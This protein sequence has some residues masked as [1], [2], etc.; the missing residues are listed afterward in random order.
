MAD[1]LVEHMVKKSNAGVERSLSR[2][3]EVDAYGYLGFKCVASDFGLP[4]GWLLA[5]ELQ[6]LSMITSPDKM[7]AAR[8]LPRNTS[9]HHTAALHRFAPETPT[10]DRT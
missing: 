3:I 4:H 5:Q 8:G 10:A 9:R 6:D 2:A 7:T 1:D